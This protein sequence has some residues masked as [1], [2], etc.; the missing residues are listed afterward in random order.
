MEGDRCTPLAA[1]LPHVYG[2]P[3]D[4]ALNFVSHERGLQQFKLF[5]IRVVRGFSFFRLP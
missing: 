4:G 5:D 1:G 3:I 2:F